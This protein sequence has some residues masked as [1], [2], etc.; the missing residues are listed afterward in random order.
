M[1]NLNH[2]IRNGVA[3][4]TGA[5]AGLGLALSLTL[6]KNGVR[7][8]GMGRTGST[9]SD[10]ASKS[11]PGMCY[12]LI[13]DVSDP[14][15]VAAAVSKIE[16]EFGTPTILIN[17]AAVYPRQD[18][19]D[20]TPQSFMQTV[21]IN[22]GGVFNCCHAV[23]PGMVERGFGRIVNVSTFAHRAPAPTAAAYSVTK[24]ATHILT[25]SLIA[26]LGDRF[27]D[28]VINEWIPGAL[29]TSMGI[30]N[31]IDPA[32]AA[33]WG[34]ALALWHDRMLTGRLFDR[35]QEHLVQ[36]PLK[37]RLLDRLMGHKQR[38]LRLD[39]SNP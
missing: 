36:P 27:P 35:D 14:Q 21:A 2:D 22:L 12:P 15:A 9:L 32:E 29:N 19:L 23:L 17:N 31:G 38:P 18:I 6:I 10:L 3:I 37:K 8:A 25:Q 11:K 26:D 30:P 28:I 34:V 7:V 39:Q 4:V 20:E 24:G 16:G 33:K 13:A 5:G 1:T